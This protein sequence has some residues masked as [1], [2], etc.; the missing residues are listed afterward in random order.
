MLKDT[1]VETAAH[2]Q[3]VTLKITKASAEVSE[4]YIIKIN[5]YTVYKIDYD[6]LYIIIALPITR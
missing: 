6:I 4:V 1:L 5:S 3:M 2:V